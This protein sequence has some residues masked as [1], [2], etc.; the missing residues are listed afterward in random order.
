MIRK[1][2]MVKL[3]EIAK[4]DEYPGNQIKATDTLN[5]MDAII[6]RKLSN[7]EK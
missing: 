6:S 7:Q 1:Q 2:R 4:N 3:S 5:K